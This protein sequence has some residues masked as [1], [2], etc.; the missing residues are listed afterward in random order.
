MKK[1]CYPTEHFPTGPK[2]IPAGT[3]VTLARYGDQINFYRLEEDAGKFKKGEILPISEE[4]TE[5]IHAH[6]EI[7][8]P[9]G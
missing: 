2:L 9:K 7:S 3:R 4:A 8:E 1:I 6:V 5:S